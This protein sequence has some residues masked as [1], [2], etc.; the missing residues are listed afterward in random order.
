MSSQDRS[1]GDAVSLGLGRAKAK[2]KNRVLKDSKG[3]SVGDWT[4]GCP[5]L[6]ALHGL[7]LRAAILKRMKPSMR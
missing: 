6:I 4:S 7:A 1:L 5:V 2:Q 3:A